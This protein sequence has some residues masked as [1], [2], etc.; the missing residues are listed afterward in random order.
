M[1]LAHFTYRD[2]NFV[3]HAL[4]L[5]YQAGDCQHQKGNNTWGN[6]CTH[7][8][9]GTNFDSRIKPET[10]WSFFTSI[11]CSFICVLKRILDRNVETVYINLWID[12]GLVTVCNNQGEYYDGKNLK[13]KT[14]KRLMWMEWKGKEKE[15][16]SQKDKG[17]VEF[18]WKKKQQQQKEKNKIWFD[19]SIVA[20]CEWNEKE[21]K[22]EWIRNNF[23]GGHRDWVKF[24]KR[25][26][27][28]KLGF[29]FLL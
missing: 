8:H 13:I 3:S 15:I 10:R 6:G 4:I 28:K 26:L 23:L 11:Y 9:F 16:T 14:N 25:K 7:K 27:M 21:E 12:T 19:I 24:C 18:C 1:F 29:T 20:D 2:H 17:T 22:R 5:V